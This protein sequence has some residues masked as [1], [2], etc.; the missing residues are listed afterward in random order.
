MITERELNRALLARQ[1]LLEPIA[2]PLQDVVRAI[3]A[4][5]TQYWPALGA[6]LWSRTPDL[7]PDQVYAALAE[8]RL[9]T[10]TL[11]RGTIH[12]VAAA[13]YPA[14]ARVTATSTVA[15]W[16]GTRDRPSS[17]AARLESELFEFTRQART[18]EEINDWLEQWV[19]DHPAALSQAELAYQRGNR[20]RA[21]RSQAGLL[22]APADG[23]WG[24]KTP[25]L[26]RAAPVSEAPATEEALDD[27]I[28]AHLRAFGPAAADDVSSWIAWTMTSVRAALT[29]MDDLVT[30]TDEAGRTLY[31]LPDAPRPDPETPAPVRLLPWFDSTLL[32]YAPKRRTRILPEKLRDV[33][34]VKVNGQLKPTFLVDGMVAGMWSIKVAKRTATLTL[35]PLTTVGR[36]ERSALETEA[37]RL[38]RFCQPAAKHHAVRYDA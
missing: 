16:M 13:E 1:G 23:R 30:F 28:R 2:A 11:L 32:A 19:A 9:L 27:V 35:M 3:G 6:A 38:V 17:E 4:V 36:T 14:Y 18:A 22:R 34:Y 33:V 29:R 26:F 10:G 15:Q 12:T 31:D 5:Q 20:W 25:S 8:A 21:F 37:E 7:E 24:P